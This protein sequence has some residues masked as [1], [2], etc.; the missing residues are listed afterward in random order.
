VIRHIAVR[1]SAIPNP[2]VYFGSA[3]LGAVVGL[4]LKL[5]L[6]WPW[7]TVAAAAAIGTTASWIGFMASAFPNR[8]DGPGRDMW[9]AILG[10]FAPKRSEAR[11]RR[12][13][14]ELWRHPPF[15]L[16]GLGPS[17]TGMRLMGGL[18]GPSWRDVTSLTLLHGDPEAEGGGFL[19]VETSIRKTGPNADHWRRREAHRLWLEA[20]QPRRR[21]SPP[22]PLAMENIHRELASRP[23]PIWLDIEIPVE[24]TPV[25]FSH[26]AEGPRWVASAPIGEVQVTIWGRD[27]PIQG[28]QL[29]RVTD[30]S[31]YIAGS[32]RREEEHRTGE[33][34]WTG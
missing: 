17:W 21:S 9:S 14:E 31:S 23:D 6:G 20:L 18:G 13:E 15:V 2:A 22:D 11:R 1:R 5:L 16:Y 25:T 32:R 30:A 24:D 7:W 8:A 4:G 3:A 28:L 27:W 26:L 10:E 34:P 19:R 12:H 33:G 29:E